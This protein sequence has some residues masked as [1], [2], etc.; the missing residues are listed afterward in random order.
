MDKNKHS[1]LMVFF[2]ISYVALAIFASFFAY[3]YIQNKGL[4]A[5]IALLE[6]KTMSMLEEGKRY[7]ELKA[8][9]NKLE[10][11]VM[12]FL[13]WRF[14][15][16]EQTAQATVRLREASA[17]IA[18]LKKDKSL[19]NLFYYNLGLS[20]I[21]SQDL[22]SAIT[23][24]EKALEYKPKDAWSCYDLGLLY[25]VVGNN[26]KKAERY[27]TEYLRLDPAGV[28]VNDVKMRLKGLKT[29]KRKGQ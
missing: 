25:S 27:Y 9:T 14:V 8:S 22:N 2:I 21:L 5:S 29:E 3:L 19:L 7:Q 28:Y 18:E 10:D 16:K 26:A 23:A 1:L 6:E 12:G 13:E 17:K 20:Y 4:R 24:F 11:D 15:V